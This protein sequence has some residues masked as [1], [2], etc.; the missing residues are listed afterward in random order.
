MMKTKTIH[1][2]WMHLPAA[3]VLLGTMIYIV[4]SMPLPN[5]APIHFDMQGQPDRY[6]SPW[7]STLLL[8]GL[9][10]LYI[11]LSVWLDELWA[12]QE[13]QKAFN[14]MSLLDDFTVAALAAMQ[15]TYIEMLKSAN[16]VYVFPWLV[17]LVASGLITG[18]AFILEKVRPYR[19]YEAYLAIDDVSQIKAEV[20]KILKSGQPLAYWEVQNPAYS[21]ALAITVPLL[22]VVIAVTVWSEAPRL[23][24]LIA[25]AGLSLTTIYG[26][27]RTSVTKTHLTVRMGIW[28]IRL[29][30]LK[31]TDISSVEVHSY[32]PLRDFG[33]Y[34][35]RF[36]KEM[37][38]YFLRGNRGVKITTPAGKKY[39]IGSD[40][41]E[42]L[43]AVINT[44]KG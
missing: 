14:W 25:L 29:L 24:V 12:R 35:I 38:A 8:I 7:G 41:A 28:G 27:F 13:K 31:T 18:L 19:R 36:N 42:R 44:I 2:L 11:V 34:G 4:L 17:V 3:L 22:M 33:G 21:S 1:P 32:S 20:S 5:P 30:K 40:H 26:G 16:Y 23:S 6:G 43:A 10:L 9:A 39:L 37:K 15:I